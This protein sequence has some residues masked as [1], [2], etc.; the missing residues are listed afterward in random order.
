MQLFSINTGSFK[1]DGGAMFGVVPKTIWSKM[2]SSDENNLCT[3]ASR[4]LLIVVENKKILIDTGIGNKQTLGV[5]RHFQINPVPSLLES[6][7]QINILPDQITDVIHS[8]LHFDHCGGSIDYVEGRTVPVFPNA[9]YWVSSKQW[10]W[11]NNPNKREIASFLTEN[12]LPMKECGLLKLIENDTELYSGIFLKMFDG[13]TS[14]QIIPHISYK[15]TKI[16]FMADLLPSTAHIHVPFIMSYDINALQ[17]LKEKEEFLKEA[18]A[19]NYVLYYQ[20]DYN[21]ECS[22][23]QETDKGFKVKDTFLL[24]DIENFVL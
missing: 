6:L 10:E 21:N 13:H 3:W 9:N 24:K 18:V 1:L 14:G 12:I 11:A 7:K 22:T 20:H 4:S 8:H 16:V 19:K 23:I 15:N 5:L 17:T 2:Y